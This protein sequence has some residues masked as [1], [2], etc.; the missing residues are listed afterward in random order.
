MHAVIDPGEV[1]EKIDAA[2]VS[3]GKGVENANLH[4][5]VDI[6]SSDQRITAG[7]VDIIHQHANA[8]SPICGPDQAFREDPARRIDFPDVVLNVQTLFCE[9]GQR[10][11]RREGLA[12]MPDDREPGFSRMPHSRLF[13]ELA[14]AGVEVIWKGR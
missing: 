2:P 5:R 6:H 13:E 14:N 1:D 8:Y 9:F 10:D 11:A 12:A 3:V 4:P 7:K